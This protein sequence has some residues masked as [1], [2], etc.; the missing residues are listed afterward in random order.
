MPLT[1]VPM[2]LSVAM[3]VAPLGPGQQ[4]RIAAW[5]QWAAAYR[6][7]YEPAPFSLQIDER[8]TARCIEVSLRQNENIDSPE[9]RAATEALIAA[10]P[11][12]VTL[13]NTPLADAGSNPKSAGVDPPSSPAYR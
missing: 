8:F 13:L 6:D 9:Q 12:L 4:S 5:L 2:L 10:T 7:C 1:P 3:A 11:Q